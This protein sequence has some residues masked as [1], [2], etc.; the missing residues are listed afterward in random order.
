[1]SLQ[2]SKPLV[3]ILIDNYN[4]GRFLSEAI[5]SALNQTY[6]NIEV[7]VVD[8]GS[9]DNSRQIISAYGDRLIPVLKEN[10]GQASA[11]NAG[12]AASSGEIICILDSDDSFLPEKVTEVVEVFSKHQDIGWCFHPLKLVETR[13]GALL[14]INPEGASR[15]CDFRQQMRS[16]G[17]LRFRHPA[18]SGLCFKR[19][20]LQLILPMPEVIRITSDHYLKFMSSA[21]SK[22][23]FLAQGLAI[24][25]V[26]GDN[27]FTLRSD[28]Q[29]VGARVLVLT[30]YWL[31]NKLPA[32]AKFT[33]KMFATGLGIYQHNGGIETEYR[34]I[35]RS[36]M[37][38][39]SLTE[40]LKI[41][42]RV[43]YHY[44]KRTLVEN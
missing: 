33:N 8:D 19:S 36:Y 27:A 1:V 5:D 29:Q 31:R 37:S 3:S 14:K 17:K 22:G 26:H 23:F 30:A 20:L 13:T 42:L 32:I 12:F 28:K 40:K 25:K 43:L 2:E 34:E 9:T 21:L 18:T 44:L 4:Y 24:Q 15:A 38:S 6:P 41:N 11:F 35:V 10:G 7:V 39:V 16:K